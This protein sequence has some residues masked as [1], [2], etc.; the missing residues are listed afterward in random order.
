MV[1]QNFFFSFFKN[2]VLK[3][4]FFNDGTENDFFFSVRCLY[5]FSVKLFYLSSFFQNKI[6]FFFSYV[7][8]SSDLCVVFFFSEPVVRLLCSHNLRPSKRPQSLE[9]L[10]DFPITL[11]HFIYNFWENLANFANERIRRFDF[12]SFFFLL[13]SSW[14]V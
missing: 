9:K 11:I 3:T 2:S 13:F 4:H 10:S 1:V 14:T 8:E 7:I 6:W 5:E 12:T